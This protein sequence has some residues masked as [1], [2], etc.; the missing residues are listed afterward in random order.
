MMHGTVNVKCTN[1]GFIY[2]VQSS[3]SLPLLQSDGYIKTH[4]KLLTEKYKHFPFIAIEYVRLMSCGVVV[5]VMMMMSWVGSAGY[6]SVWLVCC[7]LSFFTNSFLIKLCHVLCHT[8][9]NTGFQTVYWPF[10]VYWNC[11]HGTVAMFNFSAAVC[12]AT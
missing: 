6:C 1:A 10:T 8:V 3:F 12:W 7:H 9:G 4:K 11:I 5:V 2:S